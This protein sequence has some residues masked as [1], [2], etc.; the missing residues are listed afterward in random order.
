MK[1]IAV[2][3]HSVCGNDYLIA[4]TFYESFI[5]NGQKNIS[6]CR[7]EDPDWKSQPDTP[8]IAQKHLNDMF[9]LP[10]ATPE[11]LLDKDLVILG[12]PTYFGNV[13]SEMKIFM[14]ATSKYWFEGRFAGTKLAAFTSFGSSETGGNLCLQAIHTYGQHMGMISI[15]IPTNLVKG[16]I[17]APY[18]ILYNSQSKYAEQL[19]KETITVIK[20]FSQYLLK[21]I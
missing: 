2:I 17:F 16:K 5:D 19:D 11:I 21:V 9:N 13:S 14:D 6:C 18:G 1:K 4:R 20:S 7:I 8:E 10:V 15:S 12:S 3:F